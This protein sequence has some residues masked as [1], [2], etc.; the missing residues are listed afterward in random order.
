MRFV[1]ATVALVAAGCGTTMPAE[2][3]PSAP[4]VD[5]RDDQPASDTPSAPMDSGVEDVREI[6]ARAMDAQPSDPCS[7]HSN[8]GDCTAASACGWCGAAGRCLTG[9]SSGPSATTCASGWAYVSS[10]CT[11]PDSGIDAR[12]D[13]GADV[14]SDVRSDVAS[15]APSPTA[16]FRY[17]D[18]T[19]RG[20]TTYTKLCLWTFGTTPAL[21]LAD[22]GHAQSEATY[23]VS[24]RYTTAPVPVSG[25][26][27][28]FQIVE[29]TG[30]PE[31][32]TAGCDRAMAT[33]FFFEA[34][35]LLG[36]GSVRANTAHTF[37][38]TSLNPMGRR[39]CDTDAADMACRYFPRT[40]TSRPQ[41]DCAAANLYLVRDGSAGGGGVRFYNFTRNAYNI[42]YERGSTLG[43]NYHAERTLRGDEGYIASSTATM[44]VCA[45]F[46]LC[47]RSVFPTMSAY[48]D[49]VGCRAPYTLATIM[50]ARATDASR[51]TSIYVVGD[52][53][54]L[55]TDG[56][57]FVGTPLQVVVVNDVAD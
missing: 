41:V 25:R 47:Q 12:T 9:V 20:A 55:A 53:P 21:V 26:F 51:F 29:R 4:P 52:A 8:C 54:T 1:F 3:V 34:R 56:R 10:Q 27:D 37:I 42:T 46:A 32:T 33:D 45:G 2:D 28:Y 39:L 38:R 13:T 48:L 15:D 31:T 18:L 36:D 24:A 57:S 44:R 6:D 50:S 7:V 11:A 22:R 16:S 17:V 49:A 14:R 19:L 5:A 23:T 35:G 30:T 40:N 43:G